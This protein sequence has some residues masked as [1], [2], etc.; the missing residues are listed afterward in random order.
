MKVKQILAAKI[1]TEFYTLNSIQAKF[2][3]FYIKKNYNIYIYYLKRSSSKLCEQRFIFK[4]QIHLF[5]AI[6]L[7]AKFTV[8][9]PC[10]YRKKRILKLINRRKDIFPLN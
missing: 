2:S 4:K 5:V 9:V 10:E 7:C 6:N 3:H 8:C 1:Y